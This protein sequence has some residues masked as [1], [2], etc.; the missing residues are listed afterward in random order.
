MA[1]KQFKQAVAIVAL[2]IA[3][4]IAQSH[5][6]WLSPISHE[7]PVGEQAQ[8]NVRVGQDFVGTTYPFS[9][10]F[11]S[12]FL[13][14]GSS[15]VELK[16]RLG[17]YP[18][19]QP[20]METEGLYLTT[21]QTHESPLT[22]KTIDKFHSF[23]DFHGLND[24]IEKHKEYAYPNKYIKEQYFRNAKTY[25]HAGS[26]SNAGSLQAD[27]PVFAAQGQELELVFIENPFVAGSNI[28]VK[29]LHKGQAV[30]NRQVEFFT[31]SDTVNRVI[32]LTNQQGVATFDRIL[33]DQPKVKHMLNAVVMTKNN[34]KPFHWRTDWATI[35]FAGG[36]S[37][38]SEY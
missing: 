26:A 38:S 17:D 5:E 36:R 33:Q 29:L 35:T 9:D 6:F 27:N 7:N 2:V 11:H 24:F 13:V 23:L 12:I 30:A 8:I 32:A 34:E 4:S 28:S 1:K 16:T 31:E 20:L 14:D 37:N 22:Y 18:A 3:P 25:I 19:L 21:M 10:R 15:K